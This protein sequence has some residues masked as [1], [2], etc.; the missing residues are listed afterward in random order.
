MYSS[1]K[2]LTVWQKAM[3]LAEAVYCLTRSFPKEE[4]SG[5]TNQLRRAAVSIASNIAEGHGR[6]SEKEFARFLDI[7]S[8]SAQEVATQIELA[9][10]FGYIHADQ[11][12][13]CDR[14]A[15]EVGKMLFALK[16]TL[17]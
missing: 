11:L 2:E 4:L 6:G 3:E 17:N 5:L 16:K 10:R 15:N 12:R 14:L 8:G 7:A 9:H 1:Y 13:Q